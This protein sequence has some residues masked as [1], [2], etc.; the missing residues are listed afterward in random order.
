MSSI[1]REKYDGMGFMEALIAVA[2]VGAAS[3]VLMQIASNTMKK[4]VQN[5]RLDNMTQYA[6]E[7]AVML[8]DIATRDRDDDADL[9]PTAGTCPG[10]YYYVVEVE[11]AD[12][13]N[14]GTKK[15]YKF[16]DV[17]PNALTYLDARNSCIKGGEDYCY[18]TNKRGNSYTDDTP[19]FFRFV[20]LDFPSEDALEDAA[21][22]I[23]KVYV[24]Q[25]VNTTSINTTTGNYVADYTY[26]TA[27]KL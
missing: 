17:C 19:E 5:E 10:D 27:I 8:Q 1:C 9:F 3:V 16:A 15:E 26:Y 6:Y 23:A 11:V 12:A 4:L 20:Y 25:I 13:V 2:V 21:Y 24:G 7:G 14:G 18:I 22:I